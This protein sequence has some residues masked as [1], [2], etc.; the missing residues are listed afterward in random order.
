MGTAMAGIALIAQ[1][2]DRLSCSLSNEVSP[3]FTTMA[4]GNIAASQIAIALGIN[5]PSMTVSTACAS[6]GDAI[7]LAAERIMKDE[8]DSMLAVGSESILCPVM[9]RS[10][11]RATVSYTHLYYAGNI[12][13]H[14]YGISEESTAENKSAKPASFFGLKNTDE[15]V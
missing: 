6:G 1:T 5:G 15:R 11:S 3:R 13:F 7:A 2:Q 12:V 8:A 4:L 9:I 14:I 10:L